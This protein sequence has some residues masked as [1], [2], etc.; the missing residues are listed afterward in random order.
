MVALVNPRELFVDALATYRLTRLVTEDTLTL[1]LRERAI[2]WAYGATVVGGTSDRTVNLLNMI[3][4]DDL[5]P[6]DAPDYWQQVME[7]DSDPPKV[8]TLVTCPWCTGMWVAFGV[9]A[10]R[11][12]V[13][14]AWSPLAKALALS[15]VAGLIAV[16]EP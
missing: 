16:N 8:A 9:V 7:H 10:A 2:A 4:R 15:A 5:V 14:R 11:R 12:F 1:E 6:L 3:E 13:P